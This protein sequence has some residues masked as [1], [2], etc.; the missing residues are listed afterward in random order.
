MS[1]IESLS[2]IVFVL[3]SI[4]ISLPVM[5]LVAFLYLIYW[6]FLKFTIFFVFGILLLLCFHSAPEKSCSPQI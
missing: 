1:G 4:T 6:A 3:L 2:G 5:L